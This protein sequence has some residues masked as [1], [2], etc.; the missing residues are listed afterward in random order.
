M[1]PLRL[2]TH[3]ELNLNCAGNFVNIA[4]KFGANS[5]NKA[6]AINK[7]N[8]KGFSNVDVIDIG[9]CNN[10]LRILL[11]TEISK[12]CIKK[13]YCSVKINTLDILKNC[14][15]NINFE[16]IYVIYSCYGNYNKYIK[17][18]NHCNYN[19]YLIIH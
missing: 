6:N 7:E 17:N 9:T 4:R 16:F 14:P 18:I 3:L 15:D 13:R 1:L 12:N 11:N 2:S 5:D 8:C 10:D 19:R